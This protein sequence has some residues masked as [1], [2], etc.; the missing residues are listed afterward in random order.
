MPELQESACQ[1]VK[2]VGDS[3]VLQ[4]IASEGLSF[5]K[6]KK[7][8]KK[9]GHSLSANHEEDANGESKKLL[10]IHIQGQPA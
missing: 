10:V 4:R 1:I 6:K 2:S 7:G 9:Q 5:V 3:T 8:S